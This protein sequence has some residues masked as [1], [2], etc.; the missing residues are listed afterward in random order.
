MCYIWLVLL[1]Y[2]ECQA[3]NWMNERGS[4]PVSPLMVDDSISVDMWAD[5]HWYASAHQFISK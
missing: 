1:L 4:Q 3:L 5:V 2:A